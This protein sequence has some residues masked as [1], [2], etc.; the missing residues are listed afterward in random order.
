MNVQTQI[1]AMP[2]SDRITQ[3]T[4]AAERFVDQYYRAIT[5]GGAGKYYTD[6]SKVVWNG[7]GMGGA[8]FKQ[9]VLSQLGRENPPLSHFDVHA[10]DVHPLGDA[11]MLV[12]VGGLCRNAGKKTQFSQ[13]LVVEKA[14]TLSYVVSDCFRLV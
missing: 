6:A 3:T 8:Q 11:Q 2:A 5:R 13:T 4:Q 1:F 12:T 14:G 9:Q 7:T 10:L